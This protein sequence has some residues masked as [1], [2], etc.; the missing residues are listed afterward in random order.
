MVLY[1]WKY[2]ASIYL[3]KAAIETLEKNVKYVQS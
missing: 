3:F 1:A 2:S